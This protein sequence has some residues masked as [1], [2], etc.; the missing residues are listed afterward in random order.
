MPASRII[1]VIDAVCH[2]SSFVQESKNADPFTSIG[3]AEWSVAPPIPFMIWNRKKSLPIQ[4]LLEKTLLKGEKR[5]IPFQIRHKESSKLS[6]VLS[7]KFSKI[8]TFTYYNVHNFMFIKRGQVSCPE[9]V[10]QMNPIF[11]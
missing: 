1:S 11:A 4:W 9:L 5:V 8:L 2:D 10:K 7:I 3:I 6:I